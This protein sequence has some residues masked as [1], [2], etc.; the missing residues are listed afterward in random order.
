MDSQHRLKEIPD[1]ID[2]E[3]LGLNIVQLAGCE[4]HVMAEAARLNE[5]R[6][7]AIIDINLDG[8]SNLDRAARIVDG[9][10]AAP[11]GKAMPLVLRSRL[12]SKR[13]N[14]PTSAPS[15]KRERVKSR[16]S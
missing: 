16:A 12:A 15:G 1:A 5:Q 9:S 6:G 13:R 11:A 14:C 4:P 2:G 3:G 7:A 10:A 8:E